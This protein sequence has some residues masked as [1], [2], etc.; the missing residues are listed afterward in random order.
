MKEKSPMLFIEVRSEPDKVKVEY[1]VERH[2]ELEDK[3]KM[4]KLNKRLKNMKK[5]KNKK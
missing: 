4:S 5:K 1:S 2:R 3:Q